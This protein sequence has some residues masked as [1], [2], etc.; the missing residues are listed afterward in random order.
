[1]RFTVTC[2]EYNQN[3]LARIAGRDTHVLRMYHGVD[4]GRFRRVTSG[5]ACLVGLPLIL[6]VGR[7]REKKGFPVLIA[8]CRLLREAGVAFRCVIV[9]YGEEHGNLTRLIETQGLRDYVS[10]AGKMTHQELIGLYREAAM[11]TL[12]CRVAG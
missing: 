3:H 1:A 11:F 10:L 2:T 9:G 4:V 7:L 6:S 5:P 12:P 8:A